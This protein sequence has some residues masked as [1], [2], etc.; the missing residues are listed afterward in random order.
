MA[1]DTA[2]FLQLMNEAN[3]RIAARQAQELPSADKVGDPFR[4]QSMVERRA[5]SNGSL[6][7]REHPRSRPITARHAFGTP[8][9]GRPNLG[10]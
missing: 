10:D 8:S 2:K 7:A 5:K 6:R 1:R 3:E 9:M 4:V